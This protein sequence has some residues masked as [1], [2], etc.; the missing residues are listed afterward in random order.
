VLAAPLTLCLPI[1]VPGVKPAGAMKTLSGTFVLKLVILVASAV[2]S[3][4]L[5]SAC[6]KSLILPTNQRPILMIMDAGG[7]KTT[8]PPDDVKKACSDLNQYAGMLVCELAY[9]D[10]DGR[11]VFHE[12]KRSLTMTRAVRSETAANPAAA[13]PI[14]VTQKVVFANLDEATDFLTKIK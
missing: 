1:K 12:D 5:I 11:Q 6:K 4:V 8:K 7:V 13:D 9:Y 14:N 3:I 2:A 10:K